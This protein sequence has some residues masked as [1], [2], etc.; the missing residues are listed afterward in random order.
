MSRFLRSL[1]FILLA[2]AA[3]SSAQEA[4]QSPE[5]FVIDGLAPGDDL[6]I[7]ATA[8]ATGMIV[9]R[10]P[11]G[12]KVKNLGCSEINTVRWCK[13]ADL[14][15]AQIAGWAA[16]R[17]LADF[18]MPG[19]EDAAL[20]AVAFDAAAD[21]PCARYFGQPMGLCK[22][23]VARGES[24]E[25]DVTVLW[26]DG[27]QR[28]IRF[29]AGRPDSSDA[30]EDIRVTRESDLHLIRIGKGE[31]FEIPDAVAFGG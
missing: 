18:G 22:A 14:Q 10:L 24:G 4:A 31:R 12:S 25:A 26:P 7:R 9:G 15:S 30:P 8:S 19:G 3:P 17:Y 20:D 5:F 27:G 13:I 29:V 23:E 6:N 16:G 28:V 1:T 2:S 11:N 21:I